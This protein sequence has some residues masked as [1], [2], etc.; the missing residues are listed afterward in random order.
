MASQ[1]TLPSQTGN[2]G[3]TRIAGDN[4]TKRNK[5]LDGY[6]PVFSSDNFDLKKVSSYYDNRDKQIQLA[7]NVNQIGQGKSN[8]SYNDSIN[9]ITQAYKSGMLKDPKD[10]V[11]L[12]H[13][14]G[15]K[16]LQQKNADAFHKLSFADQATQNIN[17]AVNGAGQ[18]V[19]K[20]GYDSIVKPTQDFLGAMATKDR[21]NTAVNQSSAAQIHG[22]AVHDQVDQSLVKHGALTQAQADARKKARDEIIG[23]ALKD[24]P[25]AKKASDSLDTT[26]VLGDAAQTALLGA[27]A[28]EGKILAG[29]IKEVLNLGAG[30]FTKKTLINL[31][32][33]VA[34][35]APTGAAYGVASVAGDK[36]KDA[37]PMDYAVGGGTGALAGT[38]LPIAG[39]AGGKVIK[40]VFDTG[41]A[42]KFA[43]DAAA[44][45]AATKETLKGLS[46]PP[47]P[48]AGITKIGATD[49][50]FTGL[51]S[52]R[53]NT[54]IGKID[55]V[56]KNINR[57]IGAG[58]QKLIRTT[59]VGRWLDDNAGKIA[60]DTNAPMLKQILNYE[61]H[62]KGASGLSEK[63]RLIYSGLQH[64]NDLADREI[65]DLPSTAKIQDA[66]DQLKEAKVG[67][68]LKKAN[69]YAGAKSEVDLAKAGEKT[70]PS[71]YLKQQK[72]IVDKYESSPQADAY[73]QYHQG[74]VD[75]GKDLLDKRYRD[76]QI[77]EEEYKTFKKA[78]YDYI[79]QQREVSDWAQRSG[80]GARGK[81]G[82]F[83][84]S[85]SQLNKGRNQYAHGK[86]LSPLES[87]I[88]GYHIHVHERAKTAAGQFTAHGVDA[89]AIEGSH[90]RTTDMVNEKHNLIHQ[91]HEVE[92]EAN[93]VKAQWQREK[94]AASKLTK[95]INEI[96][97]EGKSRIATELNEALKVI[98]K[99]G[100]AD[101][102]K[103]MNVDEVRKILQT[104]S[105]KDYGDLRRKLNTREPKLNALLDAMEIHNKKLND[106]YAKKHGLLST[107]NGIHIDPNLKNTPYFQYMDRGVNNI[108][109]TTPEIAEAVRNMNP[110]QLGSI[111]QVVRVTNEM[112]KAGTTGL[113]IPFTFRNLVRDWQQSFSISDSAMQ[114]HL[115]PINYIITAM[116]HTGRFPNAHIHEVW[117][118][119]ESQIMGS[120]R[121]DQYRNANLSQARAQKLVTENRGALEKMGLIFRHPSELKASIEN[122]VGVTEKDVRMLN[123]LGTYKFH[124][125]H[126]VSHED[127]LARAVLA[128]REN[129]TNF[130]AVGTW[131]RV[132]NQTVPYANAKI[133]DGRVI[134][135]T[136]RDKPASTSAKVLTTLTI[137]TIAATWWNTSNAQ[138]KDYYNKIPDYV[139][140]SNFVIVLPGGQNAILLP[141]PQGLAQLVEPARMFVE[142]VANNDAD[143][144]KGIGDFLTKD[145][146]EAASNFVNTFSPFD[147]SSWSRFVG[148]A[149]PQAAKGLIEGVA[150][151]NFY[152]DQPIVPNNLQNLPA[153]DQHQ[154]NRSQSSTLIAALL[155]VSPMIVDN[156]IKETFGSV[157]SEAQNA[158]DHVI[159]KEKNVDPD[160]GKTYST[161]G[162][163]NTWDS[164]V[165]GF[166]NPPSNDVTN[167]FYKTYNP[168]LA[169]KNRVDA[170][171][172]NLIGQGK[173]NEA[174][175]RATD[176]NNSIS[177]HFK[178]FQTQYGK[179][180]DYNKSW[181]D[182]ISSL[183]IKTTDSAFNQ[184]LKAYQKK[185]SQKSGN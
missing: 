75:A 11:A 26:K 139:K 2:F 92:A 111:L 81:G 15:Q 76:H 1:F 28:P 175:R 5:Q 57:N 119:L 176:F 60:I 7:N 19:A 13:A 78:P 141:K 133:Q 128:G 105:E 82:G 113:D 33:H 154:L 30:A 88:A 67:G 151:H 91:A 61:I 14:A 185:Q 95:A 27:G 9:A 71:S 83:S 136:F 131:G 96:K 90:L 147:I 130:G 69:E 53:D 74:L 73:K 174:Y 157:G 18:A 21:Y 94:T 41:S 134:A 182:N 4:F 106:L 72:D 55:N 77:T 178:G 132:I 17:N 93:T 12:I 156:F 166:T 171:V 160:T 183:E 173:T 149:L 104:I 35:D 109:K 172:T 143:T 153:A 48:E 32:K 114:T 142:Y 118:Q 79:R 159:G 155:G 137:P 110:P 129:T 127:A 179:S 56:G 100:D 29:G 40:T 107:A 152:Q 97:K 138:N 101:P 180:S 125:A 116:A 54:I 164:I 47:P 89:G 25:A 170:Q 165:K 51:K 122:L 84:M 63:A 158:V 49:S 86:L 8:L 44:K 65:A 64:T 68:A 58:V 115:N 117:S 62:T 146:Y 39:A 103:P 66:H 163:R 3:G 52:G 177:D 123:A 31:G 34:V 181:D 80:A 99:A 161:I 140:Q 6:T 16:D 148:S 162:G 135:R 87:Y 112:F 121:V 46:T 37:T 10:M 108:V 124:V 98:R 42:R 145:G 70:F 126:G 20:F 24:L 59:P 184:R 22:N 43:A 85:D 50:S 23:N 144:H 167:Q 150:N 102:S 169:Q 38:V 168:I 36:G 120:R 45:D